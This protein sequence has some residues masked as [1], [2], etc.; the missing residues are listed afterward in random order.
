M[1]GSL[2]IALGGLVTQVVPWSTGP[3]TQPLIA[4]LRSSGGGQTLGWTVTVLGLGLLGSA[5]WELLRRP[6]RV[7]AATAAWALPLL[8][9]PPLA[10]LAPTLGTVALGLVGGSF[11]MDLAW[12]ARAPR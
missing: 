10:P 11:A 12:L 1:V 5:W 2:L 4:S 6:E 7:H 8:L 3:A 9:A